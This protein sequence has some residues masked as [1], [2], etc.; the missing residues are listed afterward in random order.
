[1]NSPEPAAAE[2][3]LLKLIVEGL[4]GAMTESVRPFEQARGRFVGLHFSEPVFVDQSS[5]KAVL[6]ALGKLPRTSLAIIHTNPYFHATLTNY[7]DGGEFD[8]FITNTSTIHIQGRGEASAASFL[9]LHNNL[10]E[11]FRDADVALEKAEQF[12]LRDLVEG[13]V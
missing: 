7:E 5:Y 12:R 13:R 4:S 10:T 2:A 3:S 6:E 1:M 8:V 11:L 9:R